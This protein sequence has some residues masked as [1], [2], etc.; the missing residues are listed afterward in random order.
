MLA[1]F[2]VG[3]VAT[4]ADGSRTGPRVQANSVILTCA[5]EKRQ[6]LT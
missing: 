1:A 6:T 3:L 2:R 4:I 5:A